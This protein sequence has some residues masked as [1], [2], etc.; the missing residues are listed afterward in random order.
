[1]TEKEFEAHIKD[2]FLDMFTKPDLVTIIEI[3]IT[4]GKKGY[5]AEISFRINCE[6]AIWP[7]EGIYSTLNP[8]QVRGIDPDLWK[9]NSWIGR[10]N[11]ITIGETKCPE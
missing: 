5:Q 7:N 10:C 1:M 4:E 11:D 9:P 3:Q 6:S 8:L 2:W